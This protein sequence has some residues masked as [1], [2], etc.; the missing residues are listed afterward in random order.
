MDLKF[1]VK[2]FKVVFTPPETYV[3]MVIVLVSA[4]APPV[5]QFV[6]VL[7]SADMFFYPEP[8]TLEIITALYIS[9]IFAS[10][11]GYLVTESN[12]G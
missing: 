5:V 11:T 8:V 1:N 12:L 9:G 10:I 6:T 3:L 7:P 2:S 4:D